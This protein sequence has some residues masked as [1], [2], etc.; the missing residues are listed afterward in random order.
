MFG[1]I[2]FLFWKTSF[3]FIFFNSKNE[4]KSVKHLC[5]A[6]FRWVFSS[7]A[8][9]QQ[10][11]RR[12]VRANR[13]ERSA[14][15]FE[16]TTRNSLLL[17]FLLSSDTFCISAFSSLSTSIFFYLQIRTPLSFSSQLFST[18]F[19]SLSQNLK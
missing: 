17:L 4:L 12:S 11:K 19:L 1:D 14:N 13:T 16:L 9:L 10:Q 18:L 8:V 2:C 6:D 15:D 7:S 5:C 3:L